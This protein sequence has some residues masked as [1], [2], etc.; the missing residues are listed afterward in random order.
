MGR[1]NLQEGTIITSARSQRRARATRAIGGVAVTVLVSGGLA[2]ALASPANA[3]PTKPPVD[4]TYYITGSNTTTAYNEG[5]SQGTFDGSA[6]VDSEDIL[7]FGGQLSNGSGAK[8]V[9]ATSSLTNAQISAV[10][11]AF[12]HGYYVCTG[13][14]TSSVLT[15][16]IGTNNSASDV[17]TA[18]GTAWGNLVK[19]TASTSS[20]DGYA[21]Q[22]IVDGANDI[23]PSW[24]S[25]SGTYNWAV[26]FASAAPNSA[27]L[28]YGSADGCSQTD[29]SWNDACSNGWNTKDVWET[30][31]GVSA[32]LPDPEIYNSAQ[33]QQWTEIGVYSYNA[34]SNDLMEFQGPLD[35]HPMDSSTYTDSQAWTAFETDLDSHSQ[36]SQTMLYDLEIKEQ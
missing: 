11:I 4:S 19:S 1:H 12:A 30:S 35:E 8:S 9:F 21:S 5:C 6:G 2:L 23:E 7:D 36:T 33:P 18:G 22:V 3:T 31:W 34:H 15:L 10:A 13:S 16:G 28:N 24:A 25:S 17:S 20:G 29:A 32:A 27:Y 14:H 26:A